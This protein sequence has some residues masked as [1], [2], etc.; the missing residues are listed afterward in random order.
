M[1]LAR[2]TAEDAASRLHEFSAVIDARSPAEFALDHLPGAQNWPTLDDEQR[3]RIGTEYKQVSAFEA[4]KR[5][6]VL[7]A[8]N[9][10]QHIED[11]AMGLSRDWRPLLYCW[12]GGQRSG[13][14][15]LVLG[16]IGFAVQVIE[17]GYVAFRRAL[18]AQMETLPLQLDLRVLCGRTGSAKSR[19]LQAL[20]AEG[21][22][23]LD[24]EALACHRGSVLGPVPGQ[25][26]PCQKAFETQLWHALRS[27]DPSRPVFAEGE[28]RTIG[29]LRVPEVLL[30][31]LRA[32]PCIRP[33]ISVEARVD[34][35]LQDYAHFVN[36]VEAFC[37]RL[38]ALRELRG[39]AVIQAW[40]AQARAGQ[41]RHVVQELL[42][43]HYDPIYERSM[44]RNYPGYA[45]AHPLTLAAADPASLARAARHLIEATASPTPALAIP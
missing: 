21:A 35:L 7:A 4:R 41:W 44:P 17:G 9:I 38:Q 1:S 10:A 24:L 45:Q 2:I 15:A 16:Q 22:Q 40:Q 30:Q 19:L 31:R 32:A 36:D 18:L 34:F 33:D 8:R 28:S 13:A 3:H 37:E 42:E 11:H 29:R 14:L 12:R 43:Q 27:L 23:V 6:A 39:G 20:A 25:P 26:Q 5:G